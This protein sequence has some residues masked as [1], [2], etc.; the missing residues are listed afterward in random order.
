MNDIRLLPPREKADVVLD[1]D[2]WNEADDQYALSYLLKN[3]DVLSTKAVYAAPFLN[4]KV[5]T[6]KEGME[7]SY[8]EIMR[9]LDLNGR[10]DLR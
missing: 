5:E 6:P 7:K 3:S 4:K 10:G 1:T 8:G 2:T 9:I